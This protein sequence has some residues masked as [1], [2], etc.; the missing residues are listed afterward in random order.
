MFILISL[1][2]SIAR[3]VRSEYSGS[4]KDQRNSQRKEL[5]HRAEYEEY[6]VRTVSF[7]GIRNERDWA[8]RGRVPMIEGEIFTEKNL[9]QSIDNLNQ[10]GHFETIRLSDIDLRLDEPYRCI[11]MTFGIREKRWPRR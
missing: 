9:L 5:I 4:A 7:V 6:G 8:V 1:L 11:D 2:V 3:L 10:L